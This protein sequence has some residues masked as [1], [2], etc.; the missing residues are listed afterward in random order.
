M[1]IL[2]FLSSLLLVFLSFLA[3]VRQAIMGFPAGDQTY[4]WLSLICHQM[5]SRSF[6]V[7]GFPCGLCSRCISGYLGIA[8]AAFFLSRPQKYSKRAL[9]GIAL[10]LPAIVDVYAQ[11]VTG[12]ESVN[13]TRSAT[14][15]LGGIGVFMLFFPSKLE[16]SLFR[17]RTKNEV[18]N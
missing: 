14:G 11:S 17:W 16:K 15:L 3:P 5:P 1:R 8:L 4:R 2:I 6:W 12:Y 7:M 9:T 18:F 10:L 13:L